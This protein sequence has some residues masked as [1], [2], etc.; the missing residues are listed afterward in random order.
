MYI[1][2]S[3]EDSELIGWA[4][5]RAP[6]AHPPFGHIT[7]EVMARNRPSESEPPALR[8]PARSL[9]DPA[10]PR[11]PVGCA[12]AESGNGGFAAKGGGG[13]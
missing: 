7:R 5:P 12:R 1:I 3:L 10:I 2:G 9:R 8:R 13:Q 6:M 4:K 11:A